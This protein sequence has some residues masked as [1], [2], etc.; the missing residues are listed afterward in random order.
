M[1]QPS[2]WNGQFLSNRNK[3][4]IPI[5]PAPYPFRSIGHVHPFSIAF[6]EPGTGVEGGRSSGVSFISI[7][8]RPALCWTVDARLDAAVDC[9]NE[10]YEF[11]PKR[12]NCFRIKLVCLPVASHAS[13]ENSHLPVPLHRTGPS[14]SMANH[15]DRAFQDYN[16]MILSSI[17]TI[18]RMFALRTGL[19]F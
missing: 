5:Y 1:S 3:P 16:L 13:D 6:L 4:Y 17:R 12:F 2:I 15:G 11:P 9:V 14:L 18:R 7:D 10:V 8:R 19:M